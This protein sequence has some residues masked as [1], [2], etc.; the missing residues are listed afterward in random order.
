MNG[1]KIDRQEYVKILEV[2][3]AEDIGDW[4]RNTSEICRK[5]FSIIGMLSKLKYVGVP[6][7]DLIEIYCLFICSTAE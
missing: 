4:T 3:L 1:G 5:A 6:I 2:W 7:E